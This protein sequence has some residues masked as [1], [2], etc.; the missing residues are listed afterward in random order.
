M[1]HIYCLPSDR[2]VELLDGEVLVTDR[3]LYDER[4]VPIDLFFRAVAGTY[5]E[6][7]IS[8]I[9]S[10]AGSDGTLGTGR[11][12][13][14]GGVNIVQ[15]PGQAKYAMM[16][17]SALE[18]GSVDFFLPLDQIPEKLVSLQR[19]AVRIELPPSEEAGPAAENTLVEI[20]ALCA[21]ATLPVTSD[22]RFCDESNGGCRSRSAQIS[23]RI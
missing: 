20:L 3:M 18:H 16:P 6:R 17:R 7:A 19:N 11:L 14:E 15:D 8:I 21:P 2:E 4:R 13:E 1:N 5:R 12:R 10:G 23:P 22:P 9:L